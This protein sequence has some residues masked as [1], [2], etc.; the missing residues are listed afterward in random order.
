MSNAVQIV[1]VAN[2]LQAMEQQFRASLPAHI[3]AERFIRTTINAIQ[4]NPDILK[5]DRRSIYQGCLKAAQD[6]L[7]LDGREAALV[8]Q[9]VNGVTVA[10]YNPMVFGILK[11]IRNSKLV[12]SVHA[13]VVYEHDH[14]LYE[15]GLE[16]RV[17]HRP[18]LDGPRGNLVAV[19]AVA[20]FTEGGYQIEVMSK[21]E[22]MA[23]R[24]RSATSADKGPWATDF[25]EMARKTVIRRLAKYL[26]QS[27][28]IDR[29][30]EAEAPNSDGAYVFQDIPEDDY[31]QTI[32]DGPEDYNQDTPPPQQP[33]PSRT[34]A[35][36]MAAAQDA[37]ADT[38][39]QE[40]APS[41]GDLI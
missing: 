12:K 16:E 40:E 11:K 33:G 20:H 35:A 27:S 9:R 5:C 23:V 17:E 1:K 8:P 7:I 19:Y 38:D 25:N 21:E 18:K 14:F 3:P 30:L 41:D 13:H 4:H 29:V 10:R 37:E 31:D 22:I 28:E 36:M 6:G 2:T 39:S 24:K 32:P 15:L 34:K 26:P